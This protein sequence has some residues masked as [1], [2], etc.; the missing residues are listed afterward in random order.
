M[1]KKETGTTS[2]ADMVRDAIEKLGW[3]AGID[4]YQS[5]IKETY[6]I[7]MSKPHISQT[8]SNERKRQGIRGRR[9]RRGRRPAGETEGAATPGQARV[10][11]IVSF[12]ET[13]RQ[14]EQKI[15]AE[16]VRE[17]VKSVLRK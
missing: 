12:V 11:D 17:V 1:A 15:G 3:D 13:V 2:K 5:Y 6:K 9:G 10:A 16:G 8:K 7:E 4:Q 14:W